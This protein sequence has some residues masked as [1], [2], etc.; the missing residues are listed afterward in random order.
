MIELKNNDKELMTISGV[1]TEISFGENGNI[2]VKVENKED[3][4]AI[5]A[6]QHEAEINDLKDEIVRLREMYQLEH[7]KVLKGKFEASKGKGNDSHHPQ[8]NIYNDD[9]RRP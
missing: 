6:D 3:V 8:N 7:I 5:P 1:I 9:W 4:D 2:I